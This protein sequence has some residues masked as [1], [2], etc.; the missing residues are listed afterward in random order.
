MGISIT[1]KSHLKTIRR[2][3]LQIATLNENLKVLHDHIAPHIDE[4]RYEAITSYANQY[5]SHTHIWDLKFANNLENPEVALMQL[6]HL[7]FIL[8]SEPAHLHQSIRSNLEELT[9]KFRRITL[10]SDEQLK[11]REVKMLDYI[12]NFEPKVEDLCT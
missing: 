11:L 7:K 10:Y 5:I 8:A 12:H 4:T 1:S 2:Y 9:H 3:P 6:F